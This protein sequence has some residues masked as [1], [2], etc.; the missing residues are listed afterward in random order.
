MP[1]QQAQTPS[2]IDS[3]S[4]TPPNMATKFFTSP[5]PTWLLTFSPVSHCLAL[6]LSRCVSLCLFKVLFVCTFT[7]KTFLCL[8]F[9]GCV[10][11][12][13]S[14]L[15]FGLSLIH[16]LAVVWSLDDASGLR[17]GYSIVG[18]LSKLLP[19]R[20]SA[21]RSVFWHTHTPHDFLFLGVRV[22]VIT[23]RSK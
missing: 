2:Y 5:L 15:L 18:T 8:Q 23:L 17:F 7:A 14:T 3:C 1:P 13:T 10:C 21:C 4:Q 16:L 20:A 22:D 9:S 11:L 19:A 12:S 6:R